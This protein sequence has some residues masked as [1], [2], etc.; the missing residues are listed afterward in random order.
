MYKIPL[1]YSRLQLI[2]HLFIRS[3]EGTKWIGTTNTRLLPPVPTQN[4]D[5]LLIRLL[6]GVARSVGFGAPPPNVGMN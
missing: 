2:A 4:V 3:S 6:G 5:K 1:F